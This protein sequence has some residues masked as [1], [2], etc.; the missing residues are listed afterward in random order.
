MKITKFDE[1]NHQVSLL[2]FYLPLSFGRCVPMLSRRLPL[3]TM[4]HTMDDVRE[5]KWT[6]E[7]LMHIKLQIKKHCTHRYLT[8][9]S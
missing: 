6:Q 2:T 9:H 1:N 8:E 5:D 7:G 4:L 3:F